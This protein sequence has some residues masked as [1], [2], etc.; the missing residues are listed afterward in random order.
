MS[1]TVCGIIY[2][3]LSLATSASSLLV[4]YGG[5]KYILTRGNKE[6]EAKAGK[7]FIYNVVALIVLGFLYAIFSPVTTTP[8]LPLN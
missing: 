3:F 5:T 4:I 7:I 1:D 6:K 8:P 2:W